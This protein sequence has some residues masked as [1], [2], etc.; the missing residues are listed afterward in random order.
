MGARRDPRRVRREGDAR[1]GPLAA[2]GVVGPV[3]FIAAWS[4]LGPTVDGYSPVDDPI[5]RLAAVGAPSRTLMTAGL[6]AFGGGLCLYAVA[7]RGAL[8][9]PGWVAAALAGASALG[10]AAFPLGESANDGPHAAF[11][12]TAYAAVAGIPLLAVQPMRASSRLG[13]ARFSLSA[14]LLASGLLLA[15]AVGPASG[16]FQRMGLTVADLWIVPNA[17]DIL[18]RR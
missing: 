3:A 9:G 17:V 1:L 10:V 6:V 8:A 18:R 15:T 14:G 11:A 5:S 4:L 2:G 13:W 16:L 7:L 12:V